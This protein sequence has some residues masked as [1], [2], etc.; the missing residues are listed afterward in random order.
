MNNWFP[1]WLYFHSKFVNKIIEFNAFHQNKLSML[2]KRKS[3]NMVRAADMG[4]MPKIR[5]II[6]KFVNP[7]VCL[8]FSFYVHS[9]KIVIFCLFMF[10]LFLLFLKTL[11]EHVPLLGR[12]QTKPYM[13]QKQS[14]FST[15]HRSN[16]D[17]KT[18]PC[19][20]IQNKI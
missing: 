16:H 9:I 17:Y 13:L 12:H 10:H 19:W 18:S 15:N 8:S 5:K 7:P 14:A 4:I 11:D 1:C 2:K 20:I 3:V 6:N